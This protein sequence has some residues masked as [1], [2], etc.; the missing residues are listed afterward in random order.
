VTIDAFASKP[1]YVDHLAPIWEALGPDAG[2][3]HVRGSQTFAAAAALA[4][5]TEDPPAGDDPIL[6]VAVSDHLASLRRGRRRLALGQHG[7]GQSY[8][9]HHPSYPGG[10]G[11]ADVGL[12][13]VPNDTAAR[14]TLERYPAARV[15]IVGCPRIDRLP[16]RVQDGRTGVVA[17][18]THWNARFV[19]EA[20]SAW[21]TFR[22]A[23]LEVASTRPVIGHAH[24]RTL[25]QVGPFYRAAGIEVV[26]NF[27]EVLERADVLIHDNSSSVFEFASTGRPVVLLNP[28]TYRRDVDHGLRFWA[29]AGVGVNVDRPRDLEAA[30]TRALELR[31]ADVSAREA[32][33]DLVYQPRRGSA[34]LAAVALRDWAG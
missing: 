14:V 20:G 30:V 21:A 11:Q 15:A 17:I 12:F 24:P 8:G 23:L 7:A 31:P 25:G 2:R 29:A 5:V 3:F 4:G 22:G 27:G 13:L 10:D 26:A 16:R 28:P 9:N 19:P 1:W 32:A 18:S 33:L 6:T 34:E